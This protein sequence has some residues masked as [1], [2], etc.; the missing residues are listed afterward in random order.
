MSDVSAGGA[1]VFPEVGA[2]VWPKKVRRVLLSSLTI[3]SSPA[4]NRK[5]CMFEHS[6][7]SFTVS[8]CGKD[9]GHR[10]LTSEAAG[11]VLVVPGPSELLHVGS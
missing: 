7:E 11:A 4:Q 2:S 9:P 10:V 6:K 3:L 5:A 8:L 1:T